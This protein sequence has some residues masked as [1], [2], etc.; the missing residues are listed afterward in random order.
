MVY[1][2]TQKYG[3]FCNSEVWVFCNSELSCLCSSF[4]LLFIKSDYMLK[5][6][7]LLALGVASTSTLQ[8]YDQQMHYYHTLHVFILSCHPQGACNQY[9]LSC[10]L[11]R[12]TARH[13]LRLGAYWASTRVTLHKDCIYGHHTDW[14]QESYN[15]IMILAHF[16]VNKKILMF[17]NFKILRFQ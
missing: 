8:Y 10:C 17:I 2:V 9:L 3:I 14:L 11:A 4:A 15:N 5:W 12:H 13:T 16:I 6:F 7:V 1:F